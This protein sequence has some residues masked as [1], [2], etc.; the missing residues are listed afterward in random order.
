MKTV[1]NSISYKKLR[2]STPL[3]TSGVELVGSEDLPILKY[4][5]APVYESRVTL[6]L[7]AAKIIDYIEK[8]FKQKLLRNLKI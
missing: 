4:Y 5:N 2:G 6:G 3:C 8:Y 7:I 1:Q